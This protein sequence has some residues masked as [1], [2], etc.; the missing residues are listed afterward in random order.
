MDKIRVGIAGMRVRGYASVSGACELVALYDVVPGWAARG[1]ALM[2]CW[3]AGWSSL[4]R[5]FSCRR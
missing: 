3:S 1:A 5:G 4:P 2:R